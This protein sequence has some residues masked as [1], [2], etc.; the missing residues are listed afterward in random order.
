MRK[1]QSTTEH[2]REALKKAAKQSS[3]YPFIAEHRGGP[4]TKENHRKLMRWARECSKHVLPLINGTIDRRLVYALRV[5][6]EWENN[7][8]PAGEAMKAASAA[9]AAARESTNPASIAV[10]R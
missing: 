8:V 6:K 4:L 3:R 5:S 10:A 2:R 1:K 9:H 7:K